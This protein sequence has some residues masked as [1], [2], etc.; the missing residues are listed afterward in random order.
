M[1]GASA[2]ADEACSE[3]SG[4]SSRAE[5]SAAIARRESSVAAPPVY[6]RRSVVKASFSRN[7][8][9]GAW[10]AHAKYL[11]RPGAQQEFA[12]GQGFDAE[13]EGIDLRRY[14]PRLGEARRTAVALHRV[15]RGRRSAQSP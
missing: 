12:K 15:A 5:V 8:Q 13:R 11:S 4:G 6:A 14:G 10:A 1:V 9:S 2:A 3:V 7:R